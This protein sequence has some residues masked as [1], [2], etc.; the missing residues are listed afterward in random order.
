MRA[1]RR[2]GGAPPAPRPGHFALARLLRAILVP[3]AIALPSLFWVASATERASRTPLGRDQGIFQY[4]AWALGH[5]QVDYRDVRDVNGPLTHLVH[6]VFLALG[7][8]DDHRFRVLDLVVTGATFAFVGACLPGLC[9]GRR[10]PPWV[11]RAA[12]AFAGWV[13]LSGQYLLFGYWDLAQRESFFDWFMLPSVALQLVAQAPRGGPA[14]QTKL[15]VVTGALS[16]VPWFGKPTFALFT[17]AQL[18][19]IAVDD[20]LAVSRKKA[21]VAFAV[22]GASTAAVA[23]ALLSAFGDA[24]AFARIQLADVPALYR[25]LWPRAAADILSNPWSATQALFAV[26]GAIVLLSLVLL[27]EMPRRVVAVALVPLCALASVLVQAKGFP[28]HFHPVTAGVH[29]QW[30]VFAAWLAERTRVASRR[31]ALL[32]LAPVAAGLLIAFRVAT[33]MQDSPHI[34]AVWLL[35]SGWTA[36]SRSTRD[37]FARF[38]ETDYFPFEMRQTAA[39]LRAHTRPEERV[40]IYGMD[41][42]VLFLAERLSATP[43]I[44]AYDLDVDAALAGG[45]GAVPTDAQADT[46]RSI[47]DAH[48]NDLLARLES[49]PPAA[50]VFFDGAPLITEADA[51]DDFRGH[52]LRAAPWV[53]E[54][55]RESARFGHDHVW[56]R[57]DLAPA[58]APPESDGE[59]GLPGDP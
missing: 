59:P 11:E 22:G 34:R 13:V 42:Y 38:P 6:V 32:R 12:W 30:L 39:Y 55:Y 40:Q 16:L 24:P 1:G 51:W 21:L 23:L 3:L 27:G 54:R 46:I 26:S 57:N 18:A 47:R 19:A 9:G 15:L 58:A 14:R 44:Y 53:R 56:L 31:K 50:F 33:A 37:Y 10:A 7:G 20:Q 45:T 52:C 41:P 17:A 36:E 25:F 35:W 43:Y 28:Y 49:A 29:L 8:A 4:V 5:G 2:E 48:E